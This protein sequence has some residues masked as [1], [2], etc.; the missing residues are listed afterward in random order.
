MVPRV[1]ASSRPIRPSRVLLPQPEGPITET[2]SPSPTVR[3]M[4]VRATVSMRSV[5]YTFSTFSRVIIG[6]PCRS[7]DGQLAQLQVVAHVRDDPLVASRQAVDHL[8]VLGAGEAQ[9]HP[10]ARRL[11]AAHHEDVAG[12]AGLSGGPAGHPADPLLAAGDDQR[13][14]PQVRAEQR[15]R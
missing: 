12:A 15:A 11:P 1:G 5:R 14:D 7:A 9:L 6:S 3:L 13:V 8:E 2:N 4:L 10:G